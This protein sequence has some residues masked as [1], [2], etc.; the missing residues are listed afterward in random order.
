MR[1]I[2][3]AVNQNINYLV[4][5]SVCLILIISISFNSLAKDKV[6]LNIGTTNQTSSSY[7][8]YVQL[9]KVFNK[10]APHFKATVIETGAAVDNIRRLAR[11]EI[12]A[13]LAM[14]DPMY[15][16]YH[17]LGKWEGEPVSEL[18]TLLMWTKNMVPYVVRADSDI[19]SV[20]DLDGLPFSPGMR[21]SG[22]EASCEM[23]LGFLGIEPKW[24][25][26]SL[27]D[28]IDAMKDRRIVGTNKGS[29]LNKPDA[30]FLELQTFMKLRPLNWPN[31]LIEK[32]KA[33]YPYL[34]T[35][36]IPAGT[37]NGQT[38]DVNTWGMVMG[39][40]ATSNMSEEVGYDWVKASFDGKDMLAIVYPEVNDI[41][42]V[43]VTLESTIPLHA[44]TIKYFREMGVEIPEELIPP[45]VN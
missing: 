2:K 29:N 5:V 19:Y 20:Y 34:P 17:G 25:R 39:D 11:G 26:G 8:Y 31:D 40:V 15:Q 33:E 44:G 36:T 22:N 13:G 27:A 3:T 30:A 7:G 38:E 28:A 1:N 32:V 43:E 18:R 14:D 12:E 16:A 24:F 42:W 45:E 37:F 21:G 35:A 4:M 6:F 41:D 23:I 9:L 10:Y